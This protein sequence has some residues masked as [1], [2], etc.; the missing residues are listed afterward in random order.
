VGVELGGGDVFVGEEFLDGAD[1]V[2]GFELVGGE[3]VAETGISITCQ[4]PDQAPDHLH[5]LPGT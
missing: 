3:V 2:A 5:H 1:V 4:A